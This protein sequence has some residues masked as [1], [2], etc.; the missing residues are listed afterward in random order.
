MKV[1]W[2]GEYLGDW[3]GSPTL[4]EMRKVKAELGREFRNPLKFMN[5]ALNV[6]HRIDLFGADGK[7]K[8][9]AN[10]EQAVDLEPSDDWDP[11]AMA[12]FLSIM[13]ARGGKKV[14][15]EDIDG[16][17]FSLELELD[18]DEKAEV[19]KAQ[20]KLDAAQAAETPKSTDTTSTSTDSSGS[21]PP[22]SGSSTD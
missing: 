6:A 8:L 10:G 2:D 14:P 17:F 4:K 12:M 7:P 15:Y 21:T 9:D 5:A 16:D 1:T 13:Y 3:R 11:D 20:A 22:D 19:E 18:E